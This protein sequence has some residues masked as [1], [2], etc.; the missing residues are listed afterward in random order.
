[1]AIIAEAVTRGP[2]FHFFGYYD[3]T[4]WD[5]SGRYL[6]ALEAGFMDR[7]P[8]PDDVATVGMVDLA[9][10]NRFVPLGET[11]AWNWQQGCMLQWL[12]GSPDEIIYNDRD[13]DR[14]VARIVNVQTGARRTLPVPVYAVSPNGTDAVSLNF[15]RLFDVRPGYGYAGVPDPWADEL[16]PAEDGA[17]HV[18][19]QTGET[20]LI[21][22]LAAA[23]ELAERQM[24]MDTGKHRFNHA[25]FAPDGS[26][27]AVLHRWSVD[28]QTN[29]LRSPWLTRLL[30]MDPDGGAPFVLSDH[31]MISHYDWRDGQTV[32]AWARREGIGNY[33]YRFHDRTDEVA[34]VGKDIL[35]VD[36]HCSYSPDRK[37]ILTDTYPDREGYRTLILFDPATEQRIDIGRF[38][39]PTPPD[40]EIRCDLHPRWNRDGT[41]VCIDSI[42]ENGVRQVYRLDVSHI[43]DGE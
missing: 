31:G 15:S 30:T 28:W 14:F 39:G 13:S 17:Y 19:L 37:W 33:Y 42:H 4:P 2:R 7:R 43:V 23:T 34:I 11:R 36:G 21:L 38:H 32:L 35:T 1:L 9:E 24:G 25:Q 18:N 40:G 3:K 20:R 6:L 12:P 27:F 5:V 8:G 41:Q 26:R 22:S 16:C 29:P 10:G